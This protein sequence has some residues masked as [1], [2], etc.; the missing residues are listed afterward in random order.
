MAVSISG[1]YIGDLK[2]ELTHGPSG[3]QLR[4]AAP[5]DNQ[6]DGSSFSPTDLVAAA[7]AACMVT[8]MGMAAK[9]TGIDLEGL[10]FSLEKH[11]V[12]D[13]RRIG[14]IPVRIQMPTG[15]SPKDRKKLERAAWTC[16]VCSSLP[17]ELERKIEFVYPD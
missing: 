12:S 17:P 6:G 4:T 3:K 13:P 1:K 16:P 10:S 8:L 14:S 9:Q 5:V 11:M 7:L 2:V 15:L